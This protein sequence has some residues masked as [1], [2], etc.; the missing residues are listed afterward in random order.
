MHS[1][2]EEMLWFM[3]QTAMLVLLMACA[4]TL[5]SVLLLI[6][7]MRQVLPKILSVL[8]SWPKQMVVVF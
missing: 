1:L 4:C 2:Q 7:T 6:I 3:M 8:V 5:E